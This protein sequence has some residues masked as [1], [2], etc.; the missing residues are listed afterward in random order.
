MRYSELMGKNMSIRIFLFGLVVSTL[1][2]F[3]FSNEITYSYDTGLTYQEFDLGSK[4]LISERSTSGN[5]LDS[6]SYVSEQRLVEL[7]LKNIES[8]LVLK[9]KFG[10]SFDVS[11]DQRYMLI[12]NSIENMFDQL[13]FSIIDRESNEIVSSWDG[14]FVNVSWSRDSKSLSFSEVDLG[15]GKEGKIVQINLTE[16]ESTIVDY[17]IDGYSEVKFQEWSEQCACFLYYFFNDELDARDRNISDHFRALKALRVVD[18]EWVATDYEISLRKSP[19]G[20]IFFEYQNEIE[21]GIDWIARASDSGDKLITFPFG[22]MTHFIWNDKGNILRR[23]D[24]GVVDFE[25]K[26]FEMQDINLRSLVY[27]EKYTLLHS[28]SM[29]VF[30]VADTFTLEPIKTFSPFWRE[31]KAEE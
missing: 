8:V 10:I 26:S 21:V 5:I 19:N 16:N 2:G 11:P 20:D 12:G 1:A 15:E 25:N 7:D 18:G 27:N 22:S 13:S 3:V 24:I 17:R 14:R 23:I 30:I 31:G 9:V 29:D 6:G 28:I 4:L